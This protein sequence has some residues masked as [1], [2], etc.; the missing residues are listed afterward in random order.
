VSAVDYAG[1]ASRASSAELRRLLERLPRQ[2]VAQ[3]AAI[4]AELLA[5][6]RTPWYAAWPPRPPEGDEACPTCGYGLDDAEHECPPGFR[7]L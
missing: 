1:Q 2:A 3:R 6:G 7:N 4:R 5:R